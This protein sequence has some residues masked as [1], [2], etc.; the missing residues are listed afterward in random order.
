MTQYPHDPGQP[1]PV[2]Y[3]AGDVA[4]APRPG[5]IT[6]PAVLA[7][8]LGSLGTLCC[9]LT[10][11]VGGLFSFATGNKTQLPDGSTYQQDAALAFANLGIA[12]ADLVTSAILLAAGIGALSRKPWA[13]KAAVA[14]S[15][16]ILVLAV[17]RIVVAFGWGVPD[18]ERMTARMKQSGPVGNQGPAAFMEMMGTGVK[19]ISIVVFLL[20]ATVTGTILALWTK[21][22]VKAWFGDGVAAAGN[23][24]YPP[25]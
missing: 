19:L 7:I 1:A 6:T 15:A 12:G 25:G 22:N 21:P 14:V 24:G 11:V 10:G 16:V 18:M 17:V 8:I 2:P 4:S 13:R 3:A 9:G 5:S 23:G 20:T